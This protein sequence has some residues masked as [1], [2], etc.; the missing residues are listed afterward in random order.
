MKCP[1]CG[2]L[3]VRTYG[4]KLVDVPNVQRRY[5]ICEKQH[6][7]TTVELIGHTSKD[8]EKNIKIELSTEYEDYLYAAD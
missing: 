5:N 7:F 3:I 1:E 6:K 4:T 8:D 2:T